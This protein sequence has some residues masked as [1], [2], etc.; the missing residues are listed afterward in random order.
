MNKGFSLKKYLIE[1]LD[2]KEQ[3]YNVITSLD[4][5]EKNEYEIL[6]K[7]LEVTNGNRSSTTKQKGEAL[8]NIVS[9]L[10][11]KSAVFEIKENIRNTSNEI[12]QL[13]TLSSKGRKFKNEGFLDLK[14]DT[15]LSECKNYNKKISVTWVGKFYSLLSST[16]NNLGLLFSYHGLTGSGWNDATGLTKKLYISGNNTDKRI[17]IEFNKNDFHKIQEGYNLLELISAKINA[18]QT[19]TKFEHW[20]ADHPAQEN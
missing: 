12:D 11:K 8:E 10:I 7:N 5:E 15:I 18:L 3:V 1:V 9:F 4:E 20:I 19:D 17:I 6:L 2:E 14:Y 13:I 16:T